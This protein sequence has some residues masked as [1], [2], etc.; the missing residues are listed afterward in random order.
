M[1]S[2]SYMEK[3]KKQLIK[4]GYKMTT[5]RMEVL[6]ELFSSHHLISAR[7]LHKKIKKVDRASVYRTLNLFEE[8]HLVNVEV[9]EKEKLYCLDNVP[10][11][12][13]ICKKCGYMEE[14]DCRHNFGKF[15]NFNNVHHQL[16]LTGVCNNCVK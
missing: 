1:L 6:E 15:K 7:D 2:Y 10:H 16:T 9:I 13:I 5:P 11:H 4:A 14:I 3:F 8:L 12:H